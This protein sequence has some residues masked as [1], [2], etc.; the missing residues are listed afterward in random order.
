MA[1]PRKQSAEQRLARL[2][3]RVTPVE[4]AYVEGQ[5]LAAGICASEFVR[6]AALGQRI[7]PR[8][9]RSIDAVLV[10]L[11][12]IGVNINQMARATN[13][14]RPPASAELHT[15]LTELRSVLEKLIG[16]S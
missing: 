11:S 10:E 4:L 14:G 9:T 12:R 7:A 13:S 15:A 5:A 6:R 1:R 2:N 16:G 3:A 8:R